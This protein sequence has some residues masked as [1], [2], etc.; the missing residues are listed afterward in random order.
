M[1]QEPHFELN[2]GARMPRLSLMLV[3]YCP[4]LYTFHKCRP[5]MQQEPHFELNNG[6]RMLAWASFS[7]YTEH[8][9]ILLI[10][11]VLL[12]SKSPTLS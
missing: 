5:P 2:N 3:I 10:N 1:Q 12:C 6:A 9:F 11:V 7:L 4:F 8:S